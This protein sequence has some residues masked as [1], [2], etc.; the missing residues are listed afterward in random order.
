MH[1]LFNKKEQII[2]NY[3]IKDREPADALRFFSVGIPVPLP[4]P[5]YR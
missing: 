3:V 5:A 1:K 2:M 4:S